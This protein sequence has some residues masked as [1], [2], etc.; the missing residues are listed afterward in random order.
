MMTE[1]VEKHPT[2]EVAE[3]AGMIVKGVKEGRALQTGGFDLGDVWSRR[4]S[5][6]KADSTA[7][8]TLSLELNTAHVVMLAFKTDSV[9]SN[10]MLYELAKYNFTNFLV[11]NFDINV[12]GEE[13]ITRM[14]VS[15][16]RSW[17]EATEYRKQLSKEFAPL[18]KPSSGVRLF[19]VSEQNLSLLGTSFSFA[20]YDDFYKKN[21]EPL[22]MPE[23]KLLT[24]PEEVTT[25]PKEEEEDDNEED[26]D[27]DNWD[28]TEE[29]NGDDQEV[30]DF[31]EDFYR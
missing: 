28:G 13:G 7:A 20:E 5:S 27:N 21:M 10:Q 6:A 18:Q 19:V 8:D 17:E 23:E 9:N 2:S 26:D 15:G 11:R 1:V 16:F 3:M 29:N 22:A 30:F 4:S 24:E 12:S 25:Q 14:T 31:E